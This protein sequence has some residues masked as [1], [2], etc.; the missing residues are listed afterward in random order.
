MSLINIQDA[1]LS[2]SN[3]EILKNTILHININERVCLIGKNGAGKSTLLKVINKTQDLDQ[4]HIIYKK[5]IKIAYLKQENPKKIDISVYDFINLGLQKK[6]ENKKKT[7][8][9]ETVQI[10]KIIEKIQLNKNTLL[11][12]LSG[13]LLRKAALG[14]VLVGEPDVLLL[15]EPTNHLDMKTVKWLETFLKK[16]S[17]S[18]LFV[19]HD[20]SFIQ[21]VCT[22][23]VDLDRG[24]LISW[25]GDYK[26]FIKLKNESYRIEKIQ[27]KIS[28]QILDKEEKWIRKGVKARTT[29]NEGRVKNLQIL[30]KEFLDYKKIE[31]LTHMKINEVKN[32]LGKIIFKL[33]K[34]D[35]YIDNKIIINNF[36]SIIQH[37]DKIGLIGN[38]GC[39]KSTIIKIIA[40]EIKP[41]KGNVYIGTGSQI[42]YFDQN[43]SVLDPNK[44]IIDNISCGKDKIRINGKEQHL[45]GY[46][47]NFLFNPNQLKSLVKTLS[48][49][50]CNRL[51]LARLFLKPSNIL[52]LDEPTND[53]DLD[54]LQ[55]LEQVIINYKGTI[56]IV[57]HDKEFINNTVNKCWL[58]KENGLISTYVGN[59]NSL[60]K[61]QKKC[62]EK[63]IK[64]QLKDNKNKSTFFISKKSQN[65]FKKELNKTLNKIEKL[66]IHIKKLQDITNKPNF[67]RQ[68]TIKTLPILTILNT[69]EKILE[70]ELTYWE[71]LEKKINK[72]EIK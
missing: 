70:K 27:K 68:N 64:Y 46:L 62:K 30:R 24:K 7:N 37:G 21:N 65:V 44:S 11:S 13:G 26:N 50:E 42:A 49:G 29:R 8:I 71:E 55:L 48:G 28:D 18:I 32:Y 41:K 40:G 34:I 52:I 22:R 54:T 9:N 72:K 25:P 59:Y 12:E 53:L 69:Q 10:E 5:D 1:Y 20:R 56:L 39:G 15:D 45:I 58:F 4:G 14:N 51:L 3:I 63:K 61:E 2:F 16:F 67:F 23:I 19:S 17:G 31:K 38:N 60:K 43:R 36:S 6:K 57:S 66:E 35:F 47:K 33:E